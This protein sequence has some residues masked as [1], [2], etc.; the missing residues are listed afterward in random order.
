MFFLNIC[1]Y[2][3]SNRVKSIFKYFLC[4]YPTC[5]KRSN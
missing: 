1:R 2:S 4:S 3:A 5:N